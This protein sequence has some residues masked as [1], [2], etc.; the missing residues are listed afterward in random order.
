MTSGGTNRVL[1]FNGTTGAFVRVFATA[2]SGPLQGLAFDAGGNLFVAAF[3][4]TV[5]KFDTTGALVAQVGQS[6]CVLVG[7]SS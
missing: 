7:P 5:L 3:T 4:G 1:E 6:S 2:P